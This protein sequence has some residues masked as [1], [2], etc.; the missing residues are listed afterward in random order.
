MR[1]EEILIC[2]C[3]ACI[4]RWSHRRAKSS[5]PRPA[6]FKPSGS[7]GNH[8]HHMPPYASLR[9]PY[10]LFPPSALTRPTSFGFVALE[11]SNRAPLWSDRS[12]SEVL[13]ALWQIT[14]ELVIQVKK[15]QP[16]CGLLRREP[17]LPTTAP[18]TQLDLWHCLITCGPQ[19]LSLA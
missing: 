13:H 1:K 9:I 2:F 10:A 15:I 3:F 16:Q 11:N 14:N 5:T 7:F 19:N 17:K 12:L 4:R 6:D 8:M 18:I